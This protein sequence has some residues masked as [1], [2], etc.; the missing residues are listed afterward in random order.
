MASCS[1][2]KAKARRWDERQVNTLK[3]KKMALTEELKEV[4]KA[5]RKESDLNTIR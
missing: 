4:Q 5:K 2:L 1:D 3:Q